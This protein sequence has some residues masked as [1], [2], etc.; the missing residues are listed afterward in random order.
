MVCGAFLLT[1]S[2]PLNMKY[3]LK[4]QHYDMQPDTFWFDAGPCVPQLGHDESRLITE[5]EGD[6]TE[7]CLR[8]VPI[9]KLEKVEE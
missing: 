4:Q 9:T 6:T 7:G 1:C 3:K 8:I 5:I 2:L